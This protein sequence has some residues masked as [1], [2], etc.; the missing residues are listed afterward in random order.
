[1][2]KNILIILLVISNII[3]ILIAA[4]MAWLKML[5]RSEAL[6][7]SGF[8]AK[9]WAA[10]D[11]HMGRKVKLRL[12]IEDEA[13]RIT[14][15]P[16]EFE[17]DFVIRECIGYT[18]PIPNLSGETSPSIQTNFIITEIYNKKIKEYHANPEKY[19][20]KLAKSKCEYDK[21]TVQLANTIIDKNKVATFYA[22]IEYG[23]DGF[24]LKSD[25]LIHPISKIKYPGYLLRKINSRNIEKYKLLSCKKN[26]DESIF[27]TLSAKIK[28]FSAEWSINP[29]TAPWGIVY[30]YSIIDMYVAPTPKW[31]PYKLTEEDQK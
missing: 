19:K 2:K 30:D 4:Q 6:I 1:M 13:K 16:T 10:N 21:L 25:F 9:L 17:N 11:I 20:Q 28:C 27:I 31:E 12:K 29:K 23:S 15:K 14:C 26:I 7:N 5:W 3:F 18:D 22:V 8:A 24:L